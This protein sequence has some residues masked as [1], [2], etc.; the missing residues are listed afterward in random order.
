[1]MRAVSLVAIGSAVGALAAGALVIGGLAACGSSKTPASTLRTSTT[2]GDDGGAV[3]VGGG[4]YARADV[5]HAL[6]AERDALAQLDQRIADT[7]AHADSRD[8]AAPVRLAALRADATAGAAHA[9]QLQRCLGDRAQCPPSLDEPAIDA[10][11][12]PDTRQFRTAL[13]A[14][15]TPWPEIAARLEQHACGCRTSICVDW[16]MADLDRWEAAVPADAQSDET[17]E[18]HV[19]GARAC[20]WTRLGKRP[21]AADT[22]ADLAGNAP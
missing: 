12:D 16:V 17:A 20:L 19:V 3:Q 7:E 15:P 10:D 1:M 22:G 4:R 21:P 2:G 8:D 14:T 9:A 18:T 6:K 13:A 11:F 5:E